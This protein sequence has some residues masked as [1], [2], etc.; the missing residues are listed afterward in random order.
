MLSTSL[1]V[2]IQ[3]S[4]WAK[5]IFSLKFSSAFPL[6]Q[7]CS[8]LLLHRKEKCRSD[9]GLVS[10][11]CHGNHSIRPTEGVFLAA[12]RKPSIAS[13]PYFWVCFFFWKRGGKNSARVISYCRNRDLMGT[14]LSFL[15]LS[16]SQRFKMNS[17][18][19]GTRVGAPGNFFISKGYAGCVLACPCCLSTPAVHAVLL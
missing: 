17:A 14:V 7:T 4:H 6:L 19:P 3:E 13:N 1:S 9:L 15:D 8:C 2:E 18:C 10:I 11:Q 16:H 5:H 12:A